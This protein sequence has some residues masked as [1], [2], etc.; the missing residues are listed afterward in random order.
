MASES[1]SVDEHILCHN[2]EE[3]MSLWH[4]PEVLR[5]RADELMKEHRTGNCA[6]NQ[7]Q[8]AE[9]DLKKNRYDEIT[10]IPPSKR[11]KP[12]ANTENKCVLNSEI[13]AKFL[14]KSKIEASKEA[15]LKAEHEAA[16]VRAQMPIEERMQKFKEMLIEKGV[17]IDSK[18]EKEL[19][20]VVFDPRYLLLNS[21]ERKLLYEKYVEE[22]LLEKA[23]N[24]KLNKENYQRLLREAN[25][26]LKSKMTFL[27]FSLRCSIDE[28]FQAID[29]KHREPLFND[30]LSDLRKN[31]LA[32][33][34]K[35]YL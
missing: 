20:K 33:F 10:D 17:S 22:T 31:S 25:V 32:T 26:D 11:Q 2:Q 29:P 15:A 7:T 13:V 21:A 5:G 6:T 28:R 4:R 1:W 30:Y 9:K 27:Q 14:Q 18:W 24:E 12:N 19:T 16:E 3:N 8:F 35:K 34:F 23:S